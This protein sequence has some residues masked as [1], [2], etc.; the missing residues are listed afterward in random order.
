MFSLANKEMIMNQK[1]VLFKIAL[2]FVRTTFYTLL[3]HWLR[4]SVRISNTDLFTIVL[5]K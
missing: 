3:K 1:T 2:L 4:I 5:S